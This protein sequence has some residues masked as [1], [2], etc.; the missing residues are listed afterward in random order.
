[1]RTPLANVG[2]SAYGKAVWQND[3]LAAFG[4]ITWHVTDRLQVTGGLRWTREERDADILTIT[5]FKSDRP[6]PP[7]AWAINRFTTP[8][9]ESFNRS[10]NDVNWLVSA[11]Y[12]LSQEAMI[13][14]SS[15]TGSKSG[16]FNSVNGSP[17][18]R[19]FDDEDTISYELGL[20]ST[21]FDSRLRLNTAIFHTEVDNYQYQARAATGV[22]T[23]VSNEAEIEVSGLDLQIDA[24]PLDNLSLSAG[25]MYMNDFEVVSGPNTGD[26]LG[27]VSE[28][29]LN[30]GGTL[31]FPL[32]D[33]GLYLRGDYLYMSDHE[34]ANKDD[35]IAIQN[36]KLVNARVG[37]RND[38]WNVA[39][40]GKNLTDEAYAGFTSRLQ[41]FS[42]SRA[43]FLQP[44]RTYGVEVRLNF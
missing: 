41:Q 2:D 7:A 15:S 4:Q 39:L 37:W 6:I 26:P 13:Y 43:F 33:G 32:S 42:G 31:F 8:I 38:K 44:P 29:T 25:L 12:D 35:D 40:W 9:D 28:Y 19:E 5:S 20:K 17:E 27:L 30:L 21:L 11:S 10:N 36:R 14:A 24:Q 23:Y 34:P 16:G 3:T 18:E 1:M 22:G